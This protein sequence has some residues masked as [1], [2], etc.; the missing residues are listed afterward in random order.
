MSR[1]SLGVLPVRPRLSLVAP[2]VGLA[3]CVPVAHV[4]HGPSPRPTV[5][6][7]WRAPAMP[8]RLGVPR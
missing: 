2:L 7:T 3:A 5:N 4:A 6:V 8:I 1:R